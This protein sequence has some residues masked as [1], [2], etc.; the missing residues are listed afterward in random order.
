MGIGVRGRDGRMLV[1]LMG[2][3]AADTGCGEPGSGHRQPDHA[4]NS[5]RS[6]TIHRFLPVM[7]RVREADRLGTEPEPVA[8]IATAEW[9][10]RGEEF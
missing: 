2:S 6:F 5:E 4:H 8:S 3:R 10:R 1:V 7:E 9:D